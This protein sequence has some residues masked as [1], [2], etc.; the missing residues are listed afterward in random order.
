MSRGVGSSTLCIAEGFTACTT[1][2]PVDRV[3]Y[4]FVNLAFIS[5]RD[6]YIKKKI[7]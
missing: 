3:P 6:I 2:K 7:V 1:Y 5:T 4:S